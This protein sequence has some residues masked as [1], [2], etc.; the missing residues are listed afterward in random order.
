MTAHLDALYQ[1]QGWDLRERY[2]ARV[3]CPVCHAT[4]GRQC[5]RPSRRKGQVPIAE[6]HAARMGFAAYCDEHQAEPGEPCTD[7][8]YV[9]DARQAA[10]ALEAP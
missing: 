7:H 3:W 4:P 9:C 10:V 6:M 2:G 1:Q 5:T 8:L